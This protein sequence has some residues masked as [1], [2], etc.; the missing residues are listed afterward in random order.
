MDQLYTMLTLEEIDWIRK[1]NE[2][3]HP[4]ARFGLT[5]ADTHFPPFWVDRVRTGLKIPLNEESRILFTSWGRVEGGNA[6]WNP[7]NT[8]LWVQNYTA[9]PNYND[10]GVRN[11]LYETAGVAATVLTFIT[12]SSGVMLYGKILGEL[13]SAN[14]AADEIVDDCESQFRTWGTDVDLLRQVIAD[15]RAGR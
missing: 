2:F 7:L 6:K 4:D 10:V 14:K 3:V 15:V 11:Y 13:Q 1:E 9:L 5:V 8:T 12:R